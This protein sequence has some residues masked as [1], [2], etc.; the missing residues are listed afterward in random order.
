MII[1]TLADLV[2]MTVVVVFPGHNRGTIRFT[3]MGYAKDRLR[4]ISGAG[5]ESTLPFPE[6]RALI[7]AGTIQL[8][9]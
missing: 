6:F 9:D 4:F 3:I 5:V 7:D 2:G 8:I 1:R